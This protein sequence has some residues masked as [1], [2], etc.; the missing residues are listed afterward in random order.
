MV[1]M[2]LPYGRTEASVRIPE[3]NFQGVIEPRD[4][5][6]VEDPA[7]E[8]IRAL[9]K[10]IGVGS[11]GSAASRGEKVAIVI[12]DATRPTPTH[13]LLPPLLD[14]LT[15]AGVKIEDVTVIIG[16]GAHRPATD[17]EIA[18]LV[19]ISY[20]RRVK[21]ISHECKSDHLTYIGDTSRGTEVYV[22]KTFTEADV[23]ILTGNVELHYF[24]GYGG[25]RKSVLPAISGSQSI[26]HNHALL[27][28]PK[29]LPGLLKGN[30]V[31]EDMTEAARMARVDFILNVVLNRRDELVGAFSGS[32]DE[33][34]MT[35]VKLV[36]KMCKVPCEARADIA[37]VSPGGR[38]RDIDLYQAIKAVHQTLHIVNE[39]GA[40]VLVAECP[41]GHGNE[42]FYSWM[43]KFDKSRQVEQEIKKKF[44]V[45]GHKAYYLMKASEK[46]KIYL[47]STIPDYYV[48]NIFKLRPSVTANAALQTAL[49]TV[50]KDSKVVVVPHA[51]TT[52]PQLP[53]GL[54][55]PKESP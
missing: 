50:G 32:L 23:R 7:R 21:V 44:A 48:S 47:L 46:V 14:R 18:R 40:I 3:E 42:I 19:G 51:A 27:L 16:T 30:P 34:F 52:L 26:L 12:N 45:G 39:G 54:H 43:S 8:I 20:A 22:N 33:A 37:V 25:G 11:L 35:G 53:E 13:L 15:D 5:A 38:P 17:E 28:H 55:S 31:S 6:P 36:D 41:E 49:R 10:P 4:D 1:E 9:E 29:A 2:W 24:A